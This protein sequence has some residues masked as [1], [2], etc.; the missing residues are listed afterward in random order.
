MHSTS[1]RTLKASYNIK[2][3]HGNE[4]YFVFKNRRYNTCRAKRAEVWKYDKVDKKLP[5]WIKQTA[6]VEVT[7]DSTIICAKATE[8]ANQL[9]VELQRLANFNTMEFARK[10]LF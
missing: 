8:T 9:N 6:A 10:L 3:H 1:K 7:T 2:Q 4:R 5:K